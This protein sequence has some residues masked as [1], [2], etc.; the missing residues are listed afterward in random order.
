MFILTALGFK[1]SNPGTQ[2]AGET[3]Q[4]YH[5]PDSQSKGKSTIPPPHPL[6]ANTQAQH[7]ITPFT[8]S[9]SRVNI[10]SS[11]VTALRPVALK[12]AFISA[13]LLYLL[14]LFCFTLYIHHTTK[15]CSRRFAAK[16]YYIILNP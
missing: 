11:G 12:V 7:T 3:R 14:N 4:N 15:K 6:T 9:L 16:P 13:P 10:W 5:L 8:C 1:T 2:H